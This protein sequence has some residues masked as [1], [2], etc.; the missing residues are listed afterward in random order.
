MPT[1][2]T[3]PT[4]SCQCYVRLGKKK[5][6]CFNFFASDSLLRESSTTSKDTICI[7][8]YRRKKVIVYV[9]IFLCVRLAQLKEEIP[10][11]LSHEVVLVPCSN[12]YPREV[13]TDRIEGGRGL[14]LNSVEATGLVS[15][16]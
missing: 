10:Y 9:I 2:L 13:N 5:H 15:G 14:G 8:L 6:I 3:L 1:Y 4:H 11:R 12:L 7:A 16:H